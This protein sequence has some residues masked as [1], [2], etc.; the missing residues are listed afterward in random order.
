MLQKWNVERAET[1][2]NFRL[3]IYLQGPFWKLSPTLAMFSYDGHNLI[4]Q[5]HPGN[6]LMHK[7]T[8]HICD[9]CDSERQI[10]ST[11]DRLCLQIPLVPSLGWYEC[12]WE[13]E[14][15]FP[16]FRQKRES[17]FAYC[18]CLH[19]N[20]ISMSERHI[21][22]CY[23]LC[24][25]FSLTLSPT[26]TLLWSLL[27]IYIPRSGMTASQHNCIFSFLRNIILFAP[28]CISYNHA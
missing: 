28:I 6:L 24:Y 27:D 22:R 20:I 11:L 7:G 12:L 3:Y 5:M 17:N 19:L 1:R 13:K 23:S 9:V 18:F 2:W 4:P 25:S 15:L 8:I 21:L 16:L 26:H 14:N 10:P